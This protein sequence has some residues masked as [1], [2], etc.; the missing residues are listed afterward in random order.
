M[1]RIIIHVNLGKSLTICGTIARLFRYKV[2][3]EK[4]RIVQCFG[5]P[6]LYC[7]I[8]VNYGRFARN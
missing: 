1:I 8:G 5:V 6:V 3:G 4:I 2:C 7:P